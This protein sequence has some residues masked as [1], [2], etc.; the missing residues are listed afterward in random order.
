ASEFLAPSLLRH[1]SLDRRDQPGEPMLEH[2]IRRAI[3]KRSTVD[4][5]LQGSRHEDEGQFRPNLFREGKRA[6][7]IEARSRLIRENQVKFPLQKQSLVLLTS[8]Y[9]LKFAR[10]TGL[11]QPGGDQFRICRIILEVQH[12]KG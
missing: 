3:P 4:M 6:Q 10:D 5:L 2:I 9:P 1:R 7:T 12:T 11:L 8:L